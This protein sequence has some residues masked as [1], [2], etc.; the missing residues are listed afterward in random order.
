MSMTLGR[1]RAAFSDDELSIMLLFLLLSI[2]ALTYVY[3]FGL[4]FVAPPIRSDGFGYNAYLPAFFLDHDLTFRTMITRLS[5]SN[6]PLASNGE[7]N[8]WSGILPYKD[9]GLYLDFYPIGSALLQTPFFLAADLIGKVFGLTRFAPTTTYPPIFQIAN[10]ASSTAYLL[11]GILYTFKTLRS[12]YDRETVWLTII[13]M[14]FGTSLF[15]YATLDGSFAHVYS[16]AL[17]ALSIRPMP[18]SWYSSC[19][20][21]RTRPD[22]HHPQSRCRAG[23]NRPRRGPSNRVAATSTPLST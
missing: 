4:P 22:H 12:L 10:V 23:A 18:W 13:L 17:V 21:S 16:F 1:R 8:L 6:D 2:A 20:R 15:H 11:I 19:N 9:T 14:T 7:I 5:A 3:G